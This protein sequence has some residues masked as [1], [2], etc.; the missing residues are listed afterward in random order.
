MMSLRQITQE[1]FIKGLEKRWKMGCPYCKRRFTR[2]SY[3]WGCC[4]ECE[5]CAFCHG[6]KDPDEKNACD[7]CIRQMSCPG[8][9]YVQILPK[10]LIHVI[11]KYLE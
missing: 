8:E 7:D 6:R 10:E 11:L 9:K 2:R 4:V 3:L 1:A 5:M